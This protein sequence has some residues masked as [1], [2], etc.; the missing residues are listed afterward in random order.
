MTRLLS[1]LRY[2]GGKAGLSPFLTDVLDLNDLRGVT[3]FEPYAGGAGAALALLADKVVSHIHINDADWRIYSF[4][5]SVLED[6]D[7]FVGQIMSAG[8]D[9][10]EWH[11]HREVCLNPSNHS[12]REVGF[13]AFYMNRCNRSGVLGGGPIGGYEQKGE[14][15]LDVRFTKEALADRVIQIGKVKDEIS[16]SN[17]D[18]VEFLKLRLPKGNG[19]KSAFVYLDPPYVVKGQRLYMNSYEPGDHDEI[20]RYV[21]AQKL[22]PWVMSYDDATLVRKLYQDQQ[23]GFLPINYSLQEKRSTNEL[24][25]APHRVRLPRTLRIGAR[26]FEFREVNSRILA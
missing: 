2:P 23:I 9:L 18:A 15:R 8:L 7:W 13:A 16:V 25:I 11:H 17:Y 26:K 12:G 20:A 22:L 6:S 10:P 21:G 4:W 24:V 1:P 5:K 14:W 3:Y 19:R